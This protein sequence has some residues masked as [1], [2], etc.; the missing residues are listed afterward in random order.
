MDYI[1]SLQTIILKGH[2]I[3]LKCFSLS[4]AYNLPYCK[5]HAY[6]CLLV[7]ADKGVNAVAMAAKT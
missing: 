6:Y 7:L 2:V 3:L 5:E 1:T 4:A